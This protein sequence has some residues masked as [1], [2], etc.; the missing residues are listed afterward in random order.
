MSFGDV[1]GPLLNERGADGRFLL[2]A[3]D[4]EGLACFLCVPDSSEC[5]I[6]W[7]A[8]DTQM[9]GLSKRVGG[10]VDWIVPL[11]T[12]K[13]KAWRQHPGPTAGW[14]CGDIVCIPE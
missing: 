9:A 1:F 14:Q 3:N 4:R 12:L 8:W 7:I 10:H 2:S 6:S 11:A 13:A 5:S